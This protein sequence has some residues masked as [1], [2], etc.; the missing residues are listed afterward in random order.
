[1]AQEWTFKQKITLLLGSVVIVAAVF[2]GVKYIFPVTA[3]F[4]I[5]YL[6]ALLIE[7][8]VNFLAARLKGRKSFAAG[9]IMTIL[10]AVV[11]FMLGYLVYFAAIEIQ[12]FFKNF[13]Y[14]VVYVRQVTSDICGDVDMWFGFASGQSYDFVCDCTER[15]GRFLADGAGSQVMGKMVSVSFPVAVS[16][17]KITGSIIVAF[18]SVIYLSN[19]LDKIREWRKK[20]C[21]KQ[22]AEA[23]TESL[24]KLIN[25]YFKVQAII[26]VINAV[27]CVVGLL[28]IRNPYAIVIGILIGIIDALPIFGSG[29]I[30]LPW[31]LFMALT[32]NYMAAAVMV[33]M[34]LITY[35]VREVMESKFMGDRLGISPLTMLMVIFTGLMVYGIMGFILGPVS[36]CI[37]KALI[38]YLKTV[39]ERGK[40]SNI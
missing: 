31:A 36:Y 30:L 27:V 23:V 40:L 7:K 12:S 1:M 16:V 8:P 2:F 18:M 14:Y 32:K 35:F 25:I 29:T 13:D 10:A 6:I 5:A 37:I 15:V 26:I 22:E 24:T 28:I 11:I 21:F 34:Y 39:I 19:M 33:S 20:T 17:I 3:P 38:L 9:I 4:I